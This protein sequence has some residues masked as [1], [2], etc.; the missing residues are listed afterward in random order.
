VLPTLFSTS[1]E[2]SAP[3]AS[4]RGDQ[5]HVFNQSQVNLTGV[6]CFGLQG[7]SCIRLRLKNLTNWEDPMQN[8]RVSIGVLTAVLQKLVQGV[9]S[10]S[11]TPSNETCLNTTT[12]AVVSE[13]LMPLTPSNG[14]LN[15]THFKASPY[16]TS[17]YTFPPIFTPCQDHSWEKHQV[18][19]GFSLSPSLKRYLFNSSN[20][21]SSVGT[22]WSWYQWL[23]SNE[24]GATADISALAQLQ[25]AKSWLYNISGRIEEDSG[26]GRRLKNITFNSQLSNATLPPTAVCVQAPFLFLLTNSTQTGMLNCAN[27]SCYLSECWNGSW[28]VAVVMKIPTFVPIPVTADPDKFPIVELLRVRRDFGITAAIVTAVAVSA[29]TAVTAGVAM[30]SQVQT[31]A[32]IN[33]V[34]QQ[35]STILESQN[36]INQH[37]LSGILAANQ[38]IDTLQA[39]LKELANLVLLGCVDQRAHLCITSVRFNDSKNASRIIGDYLAGNW[40]MT[41]E[42]MIQSQLT[43]IAVLNNTRVK[44]VT[45]GQFTNWIYS[46]FSFFK[47]WVGVG[48]LG[49]VCCFGVI[50]CLW[51]LCRLKAR[52]VRDKAMIVQALATLKTG[53]SPQVWL[54]QL[55]Q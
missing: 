47:E 34:V 27:V 25:G 15:A 39:Q 24:R 37:I 52:N 38:R 6:F 46:A 43:Q 29:A 32:T 8:S 48:I 19:T 55:K 11:G 9:S 10:S 13:V 4:P 41:A 54:A 31:A 3:C 40:S 1:C 26:R 12:L 33:Q 5:T 51:F 16:C 30:A 2:M 18:A 45:L 44:P 35:T 42:V 28:T 14:S 50:L 22:G 36:K 49:A 17:K 53:N 7:D 20:N 21:N 23:I